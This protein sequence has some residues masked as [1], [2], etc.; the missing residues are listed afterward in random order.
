MLLVLFSERVWSR[1]HACRKHLV[2]LDVLLSVNASCLVL[3]TRLVKGAC[4]LK[5]SRRS[6]R[7]VKC[8]CVLSFFPNASCQGK[9][10]CQ[11]R[12][13]GLRVLLGMNA[14]CRVF[15]TRLEKGAC[16]SNATCRSWRLV[17]SE[18]VLSCFP[19]ASCQ[20]SVPVESVL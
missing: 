9:R 20:G 2:G 1:E 13:V 18:C 15:R 10:A 11:K 4:L 17:M 6:R 5:A 8:E 3:R 7:L 12:L 14:S 16:L 19:N